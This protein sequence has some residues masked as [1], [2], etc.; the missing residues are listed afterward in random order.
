MQ[1][2]SQK[3]KYELKRSICI[4]LALFLFVVIG[5]GC[6]STYKT[7]K[8]TTTKTTVTYPTQEGNKG[9]LKNTTRVATLNDRQNNPVTQ[10]SE[11]TTTTNTKAKAGHQGI[12]GA[13]LHAIGW[14]IAL[15][16]RLVGSL[17][18]WIF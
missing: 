2:Q 5:A 14:V 13:A 1:I 16:F 10:K 11:T 4:G 8:T 18:G 9:Y 12:L 17:I 15:P 6:A 3:L 7:T